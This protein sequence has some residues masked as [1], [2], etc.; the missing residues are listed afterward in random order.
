MS[1]NQSIPHNRQPTVIDSWVA[2][3]QMEKKEKLKKKKNSENVI[4]S[5]FDFLLVALRGFIWFLFLGKFEF[6]IRDCVHD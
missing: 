1:S 6:F 4:S 2:A 5:I 3:D